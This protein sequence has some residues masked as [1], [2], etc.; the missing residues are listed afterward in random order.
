MLFLSPRNSD[1]AQRSVIEQA[2]C[3]I[4]LCCQSW[5]LRVQKLLHGH[6]RLLGMAHYVVPDQEELLKDDF[7]PDFPY[8]RTIQEARSEPL[9]VL[10]TSSTTGI[11]KTIPLNQGYGMHEDVVQHVPNFNGLDIITRKPFYGACR[12][13]VAMPLYHVSGRPSITVAIVD[14]LLGRRRSFDALEIIVP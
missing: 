7:V 4:F 1:E 6:A 9:V 12:M 10:H 13:F 14:F 2:D 8:E 3:E 11:P 5:N